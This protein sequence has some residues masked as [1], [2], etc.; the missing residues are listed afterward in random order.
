MGVRPGTPH[1]QQRLICGHRPVSTRSPNGGAR[2]WS[3][4]L[5]RRGRSPGRPHADLPR[6]R[7]G[8][9]AE[10]GRP[11]DPAATPRTA[12]VRG[13]KPAVAAPPSA[14]PR[15]R[16]WPE[17]AELIARALAPLRLSEE[18][19]QVLARTVSLPEM[20]LGARP[21]RSADI[22]GGWANAA[23][24]RAARGC[25]SA[26]AATADRSILDLK[27]SAQGGIGPARADR[28][29]H[30]LWQERAAAHARH[31]PGADPLARSCSAS[32][33]STSR[34]ARHSRR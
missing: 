21:R 22:A 11:A 10:P 12:H 7:G 26:R 13:P 28:R 15:R 8:G 14:K 18:Q 2:R 4:I 31:G 34:A 23:D 33:W 24:P 32:C 17:L 16:R 19:E 29:R 30:R 5:A 3:S 20:L 6:R 25:R 27:E 9:R 1:V